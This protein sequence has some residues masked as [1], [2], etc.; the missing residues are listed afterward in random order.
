[1]IL[2]RVAAGLLRWIGRLEER[3]WNRRAVIFNGAAGPASLAILAYAFFVAIHA[4][5]YDPESHLWRFAKS[6]VQFCRHAAALWYVINLSPKPLNAPGFFED[7]FDGKP[8][9]Q[10]AF[11]RTVNR[12]LA[13]AS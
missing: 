3:G 8:A 13:A 10:S 1:M 6:V 7:I 2:G 11:W 9:A 5:P 12:H 4:L